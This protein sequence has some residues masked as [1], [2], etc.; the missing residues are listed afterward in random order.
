MVD[1]V[2]QKIAGKS[3]YGATLIG[4][5]IMLAV[6]MVWLGLAL[7]V[8]HTVMLR[9]KERELLSIGHEYRNAIAAFY[10]IS[11]NRFPVSLMEMTGGNEPSVAT[12][13]LRKIYTDPISGKKDWGLVLGKDSRVIGVYS[14]SQNIPLKKTGFSAEDDKFDNADKYADWKFIYVPPLA[15]GWDHAPKPF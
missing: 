4:L 3:Q 2:R 1:K 9:E 5:L 15:I 7:Q 8:W 10:K 12:R 14:L 11:G 6:L 13:T